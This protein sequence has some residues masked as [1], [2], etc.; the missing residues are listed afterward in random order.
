MEMYNMRKLQERAEKQAGQR[1]WH[2]PKSLDRLATSIL[3]SSRDPKLIRKR[4][5]EEIHRNE[6]ALVRITDPDKRRAI[7]DY[8]VMVKALF[9][10]V[11][12]LGS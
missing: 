10:R 9:A 5:L 3:R 12:R 8:L 7:A 6:D 4:F 2:S 1:V 11:E